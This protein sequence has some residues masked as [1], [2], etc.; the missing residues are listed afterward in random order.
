MKASI[1]LL[2][3]VLAAAL[4]YSPARAEDITGKIM[5]TMNSGGYTYM[6]LKTPAGDRWAAVTQT[7]TTKTAVKKG[8]TATVVNTMDMQNFESP[9]LKRKF[10]H[11]AFGL[12]GNAGAQAA[13]AA[14]AAKGAQRTGAGAAGQAADT[15]PVRIVKA[16][17]PR[18]RTV[19]EVHA[20]KKALAGEEVVVM[21]KIVKL[22]SR[23]LERNWA[24][25][26]DGTGDAKDGSDD[27][28]VILKDEAELS[29]IITARGRVVLD[30]DLE[31]MYTFPVALEDAVLVK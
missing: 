18:G 5:E 2:A 1:A 26:Q 27:L 20:Q 9:T 21:G 13:P 16:S 29:Q 24:H 3:A 22:N 8:A 11:I 12:M 28:M 31:G 7:A 15:G 19:A 25:L 17:G 4:S 30:K 14:D 10:A 23:I 6:R